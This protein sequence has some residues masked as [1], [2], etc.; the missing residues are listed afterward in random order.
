[1]RANDSLACKYEPGFWTWLKEER[2]VE[3]ELIYHEQRRI[4]EDNKSGTDE[5]FKRST[6][7]WWGR[8]A[9][10]ITD[11]AKD[12]EAKKKYGTFL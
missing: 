7:R 1:M 12:E 4:D 9:S 10:A 5:S 3:Y 6:H 11:Y 2:P 8:I